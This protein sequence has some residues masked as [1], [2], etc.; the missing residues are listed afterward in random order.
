M[1]ETVIYKTLIPKNDS[2]F[3]TSDNKTFCVKAIYDPYLIQLYQNNT[4]PNRVNKR[5]YIK[6]IKNVRGI[7]RDQGSLSKLTITLQYKDE[8]NFNYVRIPNLNR[9]YFVDDIR[10]ISN[11]M[12]EID[13][14]CDVLMTYNRALRNCYAYVDRNE[15]NYDPYIPDKRITIKQGVDIEDIAIPNSVF[16]EE[17][18]SIDDLGEK[19]I[20]PID[21]MYVLTGFNIKAGLNPDL[22]GE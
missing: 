6:P 10:F 18:Y 7:I 8:I 3:Q 4:E 5:N 16:W 14:R 9:Y 12:Y 11:D 13:L 2:A 20:Y 22:G 15:Y 17:Y 19:W 1:A 21:P